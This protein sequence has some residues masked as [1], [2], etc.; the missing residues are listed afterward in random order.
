MGSSRQAK[1]GLLSSAET[2]AMV[3]TFKSGVRHAGWLHKLVGK[4]PQDI[5]WRKYWVRVLCV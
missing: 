2:A 3:N 4:T 5:H 1:S